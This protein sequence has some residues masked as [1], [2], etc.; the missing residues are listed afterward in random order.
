MQKLCANVAQQMKC[1]DE[2]Q[3]KVKLLQAIY[4]VKWTFK[5]NQIPRQD[6]K[7]NLLSA[8]KVSVSMCKHTAIF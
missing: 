1:A 2:E 6:E 4:S 3:C 8:N 5:Q 7:F